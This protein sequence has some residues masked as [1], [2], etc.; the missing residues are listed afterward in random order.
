MKAAQKRRQKIAKQKSYVKTRREAARAYW[1]VVYF[2][3]GCETLGLAI[4][5][6]RNFYNDAK[7]LVNKIYGLKDGV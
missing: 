5:R 1:H 6:D 3:W 2:L 4:E 7:R